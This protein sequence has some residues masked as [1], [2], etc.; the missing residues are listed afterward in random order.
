MTGRTIANLLA[1]AMAE[2][3]E[4][5]ELEGAAAEAEAVTGE[6]PPAAE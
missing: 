3:E 2:A 1:I 6:E 4:L 5:A